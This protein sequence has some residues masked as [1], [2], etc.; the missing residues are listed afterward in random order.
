MNMIRR[1]A[2]ASALLA[3]GCYGPTFNPG[4]IGCSVDG[5]CPEGLECGPDKKCYPA[6]FN[7]DCNPKCAAP[8]PVCDKTQLKCVGCLD[9]TAC[10]AGYVCAIAQKICK[11]G[12]SAKHAGCAADA[13]SCDV[14]LGICRGCLSDAECTDAAASRC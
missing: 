7:P 13:G 11:P 4:Q 5:K 14:D 6:G 12:C 3:S 10:P 8:T 2:F 9:D 1:L